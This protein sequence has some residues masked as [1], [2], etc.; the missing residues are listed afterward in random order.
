MPKPMDP[1]TL[2]QNDGLRMKLIKPISLKKKMEKWVIIVSS[3]ESS[4]S[5][6]EV[7]EMASSAMPAT[8]NDEP[9]APTT[10][11]AKQGAK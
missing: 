8:K 10:R 7:G 6:S 1:P 5:E 9:V 4:A 2:S 11:E 3:D